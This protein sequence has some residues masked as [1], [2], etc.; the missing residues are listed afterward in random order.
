MNELSEEENENDQQ[1]ESKEDK[2]RRLAER[3]V[4]SALD[5]IRL[6]GNLASPQYAYTPE[7][8]EKIIVS[9]QAA[10]A[11][12]EEKF[13]KVLDRKKGRQFSL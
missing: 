6:I 11:E 10:I 5:K 9:L 13:Q 1:D 8:I 2:F 4:N 7:Q 3:R 12:M